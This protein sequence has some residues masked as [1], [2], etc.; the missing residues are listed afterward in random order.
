MTTL[1]AALSDSSDLGDY[2]G[3]DIIRTSIIIRNTGDGLSEAMAIAPQVLHI[4]DEGYALIKFK[5]VDHHHPEIKGTDC[6][7]LKQILK[8]GIATIVDAD[9]AQE[10]IDAQAERIQRAK[11][12]AKGQGSLSTELLEKQHAEGEH[13]AGLVEGCPPCSAEQDALE[14]EGDLPE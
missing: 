6:L 11:D 9:F 3:K 14:A 1:P 5:V 10:K 8:A 12:A 2:D 4:G 7:E 13:A